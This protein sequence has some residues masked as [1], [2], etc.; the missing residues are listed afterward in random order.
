MAKKIFITD[1]EMKDFK[2][3]L[4]ENNKVD[5]KIAL[6]EYLAE[7]KKDK[8][9][10]ECFKRIKDGTNKEENLIIEEIEEDDESDPF[11]DISE[12]Q[13]EG[14]KMIFEGCKRIAESKDE[15]DIFKGL[16][17]SCLKAMFSTIMIKHSDELLRISKDMMMMS[18]MSRIVEKLFGDDESD[19]DSKD[20]E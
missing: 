17:E 9:A 18:R 10:I 8:V 16:S 13:I 1:S 2:K 15:M 4:K 14:M 7:V 5:N 6:A 20:K 19:K 3:W 11:D 12:Y